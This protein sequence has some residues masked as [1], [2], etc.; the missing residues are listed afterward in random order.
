MDNIK[1]EEWNLILIMLD[2]GDGFYFFCF[3][4]NECIDGKK[5]WE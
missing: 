5:V 3:L 1:N 4:F 2:I